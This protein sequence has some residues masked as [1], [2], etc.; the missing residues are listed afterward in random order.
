MNNS[1]AVKKTLNFQLQNLPNVFALR[2][3]SCFFSVGGWIKVFQFIS[4][5]LKNNHKTQFASFVQNWDKFHNVPIY[6]VKS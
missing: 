3:A 4:K 5:V 1:N 2:K 6:I